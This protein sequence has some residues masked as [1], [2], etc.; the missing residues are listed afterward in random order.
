[1][2]KS[3]AFSSPDLLPLGNTEDSALEGDLSTT[4]FISNAYTFNLEF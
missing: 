4:L 1:M 3:R 2:S